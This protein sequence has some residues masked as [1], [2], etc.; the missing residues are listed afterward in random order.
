MKFPDMEQKN[1]L[2]LQPAS[3]SESCGGGRDPSDSQRKALCLSPRIGC[4]R[5][6]VGVIR[7]SAIGKMEFSIFSRK[8][9]FLGIESFSMDF[10]CVHLSNSSMYATNMSPF[11]IHLAYNT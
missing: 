8:Y 7:P 2:S 3:G 4:S 11:Q 5:I 9:Y 1:H 6:K 10:R